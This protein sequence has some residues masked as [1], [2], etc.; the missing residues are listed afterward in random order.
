MVSSTPFGGF[1]VLCCYPMILFL[2]I[3]G[4]N[5]SSLA[6]FPENGKSLQNQIKKGYK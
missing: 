3:M 4:F 5:P 6:G 2:F 1:I